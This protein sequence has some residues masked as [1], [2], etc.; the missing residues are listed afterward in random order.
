MSNSNNLDD[1]FQ[2]KNIDL[3]SIDN[4]PQFMNKESH[5]LEN[6]LVSNNI[7]N[8]KIFCILRKLCIIK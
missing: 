4:Q 3:I 8:K 6:P 1:R 2:G 5:N 7:S